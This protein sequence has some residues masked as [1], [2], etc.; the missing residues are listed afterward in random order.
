[1]VCNS[2]PLRPAIIIFQNWMTA[3]DISEEKAQSMLD[4]TTKDFSGLQSSIVIANTYLEE[5][6]RLYCNGRRINHTSLG[7]A[8][9][10]CDWS[11][12]NKIMSM[13]SI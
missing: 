3:Q 1:M 8:L 5:V 11:E 9:L 6:C 13:A 12:L 7:H 10:T 4:K 2:L